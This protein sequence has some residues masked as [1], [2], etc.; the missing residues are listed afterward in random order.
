MSKAPPPRIRYPDLRGISATLLKLQTILVR[1]YILLTRI[2]KS[3][4]PAASIVDYKPPLSPV[5]I[6]PKYRDRPTT[7]MWGDRVP[8]VE[9]RAKTIEFPS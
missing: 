5:L 7:G 8:A 9:V 6:N 3:H 1:R 4:R 2:S